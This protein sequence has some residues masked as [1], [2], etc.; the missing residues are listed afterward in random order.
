[1]NCTHGQYY[2]LN[3]E[4]EDV[5]TNFTLTDYNTKQDNTKYG[6]AKADK[7]DVR[8]NYYTY[9][10][11]NITF[12]GTG[13]D[14]R[15]DSYPEQE[16]KLFVNTIVKSERGANHKPEI[17]ALENID[18]VPFNS[19]LDFNTIVKDIDGDKIRIN[20]ITVDGN[21]IE[22]Y[23]SATEF[24]NQ[25]SK[26]PVTISKNYLESKVG[27]EVKVIIEAEDAKGAISVKEYTIKPVRDA[28]LTSSGETVNTLVGEK[29]DFNIKLNRENDTTPSSI[30]VK[31]VDIPAK[32]GIVTL[33]DVNTKVVNGEIYLSGS[34]TSI[35]EVIGEEIPI[36]INY[37][38]GTS[39]MKKCEVKIILNS[40]YA[41]VN[42]V[43]KGNTGN[44]GISPKVTLLNKTNN[45]SYIS[46]ISA[47][48]GQVIFNT[49]DAGKYE[50]FLTELLG[51]D[52][53]SISI[54]GNK[55]NLSSDGKISFDINFN[56]S[57]KLIEIIVTPQISDLYHGLYGGIENI[58]GNNSTVKILEN[59]SG[60]EILA[61]ATITFGAKFLVGGNSVKFNLDVDEKIDNVLLENIKI[62][63]T[64]VNSNEI[65]LQEITK[66]NGNSIMT[67][68]RGGKDFEILL[69][70][71][72]DN[73]GVSI[74]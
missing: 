34:L 66:N 22:G 8:N 2:E 9:S 3:L 33:S 57:S 19:D 39:I 14:G 10:R 15:E 60:F 50:M 68:D 7:Y 26:F 47:I 12:S 46:N 27:K 35:V 24:F 69:T 59:A 73:N 20:K 43:L 45:K 51:Y 62:Y 52:I 72:K 61:G 11:G 1:M 63:K 71:L 42:V 40:K 54:N 23:K 4:D 30:V 55:V 21:L 44:L 53:E 17:S 56:E 29:V 36:T 64:I 38:N 25:G 48:D 5:V 13:E 49:I 32:E 37:T 28:L 70:N 67:T 6:A 31:S 18:E 65:K 58:S 41:N 16:L 74:K